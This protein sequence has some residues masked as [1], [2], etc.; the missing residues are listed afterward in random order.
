M[1]SHTKELAITGTTVG[2]C[3]LNHGGLDAEFDFLR[4]QR[5]RSIH[6]IGVGGIGVSGLAAILKQRGYTVT[7]VDSQHSARIHYLESLGV[8]MVSD[9]VAQVAE[10]D[11]VIYSQEIKPGR[12]DRQLAKNRGIPLYSRGE[13]LAQIIG[14]SRSL[15]VA[16]SHGK[17]T[18]SGWAAFSLQEAGVS[19]NSYL[20]AVICGR[21]TSIS[22]T[23]PDAPWVLE[24]DESDGSCFLLSPTCLV[25][26]NIDTEHLRTYDGSIAVLQDRMVE[27]ANAIGPSGLVILCQ[28]DPG[29]Q[30]ILPRLKGRKYTYGFS[31][32]A[33][34]QLLA[35]DQHGADCELRWR[36]PEGKEHT[37]KMK[38]LGRHNALNGLAAWIA[39][40]EFC[41]LDESKLTAAWCEYPGVKRRMSMHGWLALDEGEALIIEDYGHHPREIEA[42]LDALHSFWS[43]KRIVMLLQPPYRYSEMQDLFDEF[44][45]V[46]KNVDQICLLPI[47]A[48]GETENFGISSEKLAVAIERAGAPLPPVVYHDLKEAEKGLCRILQSGDVL[49]LQFVDFQGTRIFT[50]ND[51]FKRI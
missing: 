4:E 41:Q 26:T 28:D 24:S 39:S 30:A 51:R 29:I 47:C 40:R 17:S 10:T 14:N 19:V 13:F 48:G 18:T 37:A 38:L 1:R 50:K 49:L 44:V 16:G 20:G 34:F 8:K 27:W 6:C 21:Q 15:V 42:T 5:I 7:G 45:N 25:I 2:D 43:D 31:E 3:C 12:A 32:T 33:D 36:I 9:S 46:L 23:A 22:I 11:C 35:C